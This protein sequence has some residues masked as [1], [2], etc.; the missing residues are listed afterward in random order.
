M[1][2][3]FNMILCI[4]GCLLDLLPYF[5]LYL[6][7]LIQIEDRLGKILFFFMAPFSSSFGALNF[8]EFL[9]NFNLIFF[10]Y[11]GGYPKITS[12]RFQ[13]GQDQGRERSL[14]GTPQLFFSFTSLWQWLKPSRPLILFLQFQRFQITQS[15]RFTQNCF[16][17]RFLQVDVCLDSHKISLEGFLSIKLFK[18]VQ[19]LF[20]KYRKFI[21]RSL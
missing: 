21:P 20:V 14:T 2:L 3:S 6:S 1:T 18:S 11:P 8:V 17:G 16:A 15:Q 10:F 9:P 7:S 13:C 4:N 5:S 19:F 12:P